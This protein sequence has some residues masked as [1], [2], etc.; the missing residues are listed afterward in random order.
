[1]CFLYSRQNFIYVKC[2]VVRC[3]LNV[4]GV[5]YVMNLVYYKNYAFHHLH[6]FLTALLWPRTFC[7]GRTT[8]SNQSF[9][10]FAGTVFAV[11]LLPDRRSIPFWLS[12]TTAYEG[13]MKHTSKEQQNTPLH[14]KCKRTKCKCK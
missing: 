3:K 1:M 12:Y 5:C 10:K 14:Y 11:K 2:R 13:A 4:F 7:L 9:V 6:G 8:T